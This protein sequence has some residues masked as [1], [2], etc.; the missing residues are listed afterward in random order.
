MKKSKTGI[1]IILAVLSVLTAV[2]QGDQNSDKKS[3][4]FLNR[5]GGVHDHGWTSLGFLDK[6]SVTR[7]YSGRKIIF[8]DQKGNAVDSKG[9]NL[10]RAPKNAVYFKFNGEN[11]VQQRGS[12]S[13]TCATL[14][15]KGH[16]SGP[17][18]NNYKLHNCITH[19]YFLT[20]KK[21]TLNQ[22]AM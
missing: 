1:L 19:C 18:H 21:D 5:K 8:L 17:D 12:L 6:E 9:N 7:I 11:V 2:A 13:E 20:N 10:G 16:Y 14:D 15:P 22:M 3:S 4:A